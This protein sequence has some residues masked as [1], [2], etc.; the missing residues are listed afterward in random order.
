[1]TNTRED[2]LIA[3]HARN[4]GAFLDC[5]DG[6]TITY[7]GF[8]RRAA[9]MAHV[10]AEVGV[11]PGERVVVQ[12]AKTA[13]AIALYAGTI[14]AGAVYLPLNTAYT[15]SELAYFIDD[16]EPAVGR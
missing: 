3:P 15:R 13:E 10:L 9:Q 7:A 8:V 4:A 16:A 6:S 2:A 1:V 14:Q 5:D 11:T 12:T